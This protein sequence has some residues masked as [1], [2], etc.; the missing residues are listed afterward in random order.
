MQKIQLDHWL[1]ADHSGKHLLPKLYVIS[2]EDLSNYL[3]AVEYKHKLEPVHNDGELMHFSSLDQV[4]ET[5]ARLGVRSIYLRLH[6]TDDECSAASVSI[7]YH[8]IKMSLQT[9]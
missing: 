4:K 2:C 6:N 9:H 1:H 8:D 5:L 7:P 3:L